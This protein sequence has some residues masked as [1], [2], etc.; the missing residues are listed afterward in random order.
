MDEGAFAELIER[1]D[2]SLRSLAFRLLADRDR[3]DD[4]LQDAYVKAFRALPRFRS[5]SAPSTWSTTPAS[6]SCGS[7][8]TG[9][10][11]RPA[12]FRSRSTCHAVPAA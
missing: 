7:G 4:V 9:A 2:R 12:R 11:A 1:H 8:R 3:M 10:G 6:T 5:A